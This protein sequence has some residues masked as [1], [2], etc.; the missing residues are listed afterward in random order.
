MLLSTEQDVIGALFQMDLLGTSRLDG[1]PA[2]FFQ[3]H[4]HTLKKEVYSFALNVLNHHS[5]LVD[6]NYTF[7]TLIPKV[8]DVKKVG[9]F[10]LISLCNVIYK[11]VAKVLANR[12]KS[13]LPHVISPNQSAF[14]LG[15]LITDNIV[16][17]Y[18]T[19]H[20]MT[21]KC[22]GNNRCMAL[23]L[24][25]NK[26]YDQV[27]CDFLRAI[28]VKMGFNSRWT[29]LVMACVSSV[30]Y[31]ISVNGIPQPYFTHS[32]CRGPLGFIENS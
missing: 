21:T 26:A 17:A 4:W 29:N 5:Y 8:S 14:I 11:I 13:T 18:E 19:L 32:L 10:R 2:H 27:D 30:S 20:T 1:F 28:M 6:V 15:R 3:K 9:E 31:S 22:K 7:I 24:D 25:T 16:I 12:L 23:K